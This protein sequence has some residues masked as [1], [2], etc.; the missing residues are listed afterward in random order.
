MAETQQA[1]Q[2]PPEPRVWALFAH[3]DFSYL[4][5]G[6]VASSIAMT[7]KVLVS[8]QW[9]YEETGSAAQLGLLGAVQ[10]LQ[11]PMVLYGGTLADVID[12][13]KLMVF[14][15][16]ASFFLLSV[17]TLLAGADALRPWHIFAATGFNSIVN[18]LGGSAR[19]AMLPRIVP[20]SLL[21]HAVSIQIITRQAASIGA[22][23]IFWQAYEVLGVTNS[24]AIGAAIALLATFAPLLIKASG[25]PEGAGSRR[26]TLA[27]LREGYRFVLGHR[28]LP[29]LYLLDIGVVIVSFYRP[30]FPVFADKLY[31]MG[32][33]G[34]GLL[35]AADAAGGIVGTFLVL[36]TNSWGRKGLIVLVGTLVYAVFLFA[37]GLVHIFWLG[38]IIVAILGVTDAI[39][40]T[41][42]QTIVQLT[43]PDKLL[44][45]ASSAHSFAAMGAN[46]LGQIEVGIMSGAI[47][48]G[49]TM[50]LG[51]V[52]SVLV[53]AAIWYYMPGIHRYRYDPQ[54]PYEK[55][56]EG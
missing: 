29:G 11:M 22:P 47:G 12:R 35:N 41:M 1:E 53:V 28:L 26:T 17:L 14:T 19:P 42:R 32:A 51:G 52:I 6:G 31:G 13:K 33:A 37:F 30:L 38:L 27:S 45:R 36:F 34:T 56:E 9:L 20:R 40:M 15:Q 18:T 24:F 49:N 4:W 7:L 55:H 23:L 44:G 54:N 10:L 3:A 25:K 21:T 43:T 16:G 5:A 50:V 8:A 48:A 39:S 2:S 46:N